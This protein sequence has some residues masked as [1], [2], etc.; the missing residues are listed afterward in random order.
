MGWCGFAL[1]ERGRRSAVEAILPGMEIWLAD[2]QRRAAPWL[3]WS[4][5]VHNAVQTETFPFRRRK[6]DFVLFLGRLAPAKG[7]PEAIAA[8]ASAGL[9]GLICD[10]PSDLPAALHRVHEL[11]APP[12][13]RSRL[14]PA[15]DRGV[16][17]AVSP[18]GS[19]RR[20]EVR[21]SSSRRCGN[22][23]RV[24]AASGR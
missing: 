21:P 23:T 15:A 13:C 19:S 2:A 9:T 14:F 1:V 22:W 10:H 7:L 24:P 20:E 17:A 3:K 8:A 5:T 6:Q 16:N 4:A 12:G 11:D 18:T